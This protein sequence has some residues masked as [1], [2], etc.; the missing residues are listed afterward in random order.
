MPLNPQPIKIESGE[1]LII[2]TLAFHRL[3]GHIQTVAME[4]V[5]EAIKNLYARVAGEVEVEKN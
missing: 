1:N 2:F 3:L 5:R 4:P